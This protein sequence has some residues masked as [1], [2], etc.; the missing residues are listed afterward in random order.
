MSP[1]SLKPK[2]SSKEPSVGKQDRIKEE[3]VTGKNNLPA[4][5]GPSSLVRISFFDFSGRKR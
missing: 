5:R 3:T 4:L 2:S 1:R